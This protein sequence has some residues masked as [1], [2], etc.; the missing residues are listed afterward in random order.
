MRELFEDL[1]VWEFGFAR[2]SPSEVGKNEESFLQPEHLELAQFGRVLHDWR[3][4]DKKKNSKQEDK[5]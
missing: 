4:K 2:R 3:P 5:R 1:K